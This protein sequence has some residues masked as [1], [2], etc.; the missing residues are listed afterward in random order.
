MRGIIFDIQR[1]C[2]K[3][4][5]GIRTT[6]FFKGCPLRCLWCHNPESQHPAME[7]MQKA[8][9][10]G[11]EHCGKE[12]SVEQVMDVVLKDRLYYEN[13]GGGLTLSGGEPL[14]Q[15]EFCRTLMKEAK[16]QGLHIALETCGMAEEK[17]IRESARWVDLYLFDFKESDPFRHKDYTGAENQRI[18]ENLRVLDGL[19]KK[20]IL[21]CPIIPQYNDR[22]A[23]FEAIGALADSLSHLSKV[24]V[25]PYHSFGEDKYRRLGRSYPLKGMK[26]PSKEQVDEWIR[27]I[28]RNTQK[29]V[30][31]A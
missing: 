13:S 7:Q 21:R 27:E 15:W 11:K 10:E 2:T 5:D 23:H 6:V 29:A 3:D 17:V 12:Y 30:E 4:G 20:I 14:L 8:K 25:E 18:L 16:K 26:A 24:Q 9:E 28:Q 19:G 31:R 22:K 1:F